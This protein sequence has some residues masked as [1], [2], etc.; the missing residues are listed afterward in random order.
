[1]LWNVCILVLSCL[2]FSSHYF[3][4]VYE[5]SYK[6]YFLINIL[7]RLHQLEIYGRNQRIIYIVDTISSTT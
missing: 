5:T 2:F 4:G 3:G 1:M 7:T 6:E